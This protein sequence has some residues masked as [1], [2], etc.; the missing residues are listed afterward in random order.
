MEDKNSRWTLDS[1]TSHNEAMR[2][3]DEKFQAERDR[4]YSE[5]WKAQEKAAENLKEYQNEFR[6]SLE[7]LSTKQATKLE[8]A[9]AIKTVTDKIDLQSATLSEL[10]S[11]LDVGNPTVAALQN[12][13]S[14]S[15]GR[16]EGV[17][18]AVAYLISGISVIFGVV[19]ILI[20]V[21]K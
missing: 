14:T 11:R 1:Y 5:R 16:G 13:Y 17:A 19:G 3:A 2:I 4:R 6:G 12:Q 8:L 15:L 18:K 9:A 21:L 7:D 20:A 10:R